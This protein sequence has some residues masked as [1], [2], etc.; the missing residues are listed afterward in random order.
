[1]QQQ[2]GHYTI[3]RKLG[4]GAMGVVFAA[5]D[6]RL[7]R[8]VAIKIIQ[9][10]NTGDTARQRFWREARAAAAVNHPNIC[11][12]YEVGEHEGEM[13]V[14]M[15]LLEGELLAD[16]ISRGAIAIGEALPMAL[17]VLD[18]LAAIHRAGLVHRDLKPSNLFITPHG[19]K[20]LDFGLARVTQTDDSKTA[21][22]LTT[23]G[24]IVGTPRYMAPE[25][26]SGEEAGP[27]TDLFACGT[28][29][30]EMLTGKP[31]FE[32]DSLPALCHA[33]VHT[34]PPALAGGP[35]VQALDRVIARALAKR[36][37]DRYPDAGSMAQDLRG[38]NSAGSGIVATQ[39]IRTITRMMVL[40]FRLLR[41]DAD[42]DF[43]PTSLADAVTASLCGLES[44]VVRSN[45]AAGIT[46]DADVKKVVSDADVDLVLLGTLLRSGDKLRLNA[47][48]IDASG[49]VVWSK[50]LQS[51]F[52]DIFDLQDELTDRLIE[53]L[54]MPLSQSSEEQL[55]RDVPATAR[56]YELYLRAMHVGVDSLSTSRLLAARDLL[57]ECVRED[58][59]F[60][61][62]W[63]RLG[64]VHRIIAKYGHE[65]PQDNRRSAEEAFRKALEINPDLPLAH[66]LYTYFELEEMRN[67]PGAITRLLD[68]VRRRPNDPDLFA[69]LVT[70]CRFGGMLGASM[71]AD[72][73]A[74]RLDPQIV[75]SVG[76]T[77]WMLHDYRRV[78]EVGVPRGT[79]DF[80]LLMARAETGERDEVLEDMH[81]LAAN[82]DGSERDVLLAIA[83]SLEGDRQAAVEASIR[84]RR[85]Q[86]PDPEHWFVW[87]TQLARVRE[88]DMALEGLREAIDGNF[89]CDEF[90]TRESSF[91]FLRGDPEFERLIEDSRDRHRRAASLF[92]QAGGEE[93]LGVGV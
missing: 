34:Q 23:P 9:K 30:F 43:L 75:T 33:I 74:R 35:E 20:L 38:I 42:I 81:R 92:R 3:T 70:A 1:M 91:D 46:G 32:G 50:T 62:A 26:W 49:R 86:V 69:G 53:S 71:A 76:Y 80:P 47:Q 12:I 59:R 29:L 65:A 85:A 73:R 45:R 67:M 64:R 61:P 87:A 37:A 19:V 68:Q 25:Q 58:P 57:R 89:C 79:I 83:G 22:L 66:N 82:A 13:F 18:G 6:D 44:L 27:A 88:K 39:A 17:S 28:I 52:N 55:H 5:R 16:R 21:Q 54:S 84:L 31:A 77:Y 40:P 51:A 63:A 48:L 7:G 14:A 72:Q 11:H 78:I 56:A 15:E 41:P 60:A 24:T 36:A 8:T 2:I 10:Q 93:L 90:L 4:E